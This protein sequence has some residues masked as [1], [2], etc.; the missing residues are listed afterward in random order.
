MIS[1]LPLVINMIYCGKVQ[2][3]TFNLQT[4]ASLPEDH[5]SSDLTTTDS[6]VTRP[7]RKIHG[8][9]A[10]RA[11]DRCGLPAQIQSGNNTAEHN[12]RLEAAAFMSCPT[13]N[14]SIS[15]GT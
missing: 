4:C 14:Y 12:T 10:K 9:I 3:L 13:L 7:S 11:T 15:K 8:D 1:C 5:Q 2:S 6:E